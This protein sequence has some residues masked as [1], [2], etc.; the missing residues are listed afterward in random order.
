MANKVQEGSERKDNEVWGWAGAETLEVH[1][2]KDHTG[3]SYHRR[4]INFTLGDSR[5]IK[6]WATEGRNNHD[7]LR[8]LAEGLGY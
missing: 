7:G 4:Q 2:V 8:S 3:T 5:L 1:M 6:F